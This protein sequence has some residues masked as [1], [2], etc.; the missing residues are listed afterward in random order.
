MAFQGALSD[1]VAFGQGKSDSE[2]HLG[3]T[4]VISTATAQKGIVTVHD[5][6]NPEPP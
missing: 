6:S 5:V 1:V 3:L 2:K 4:W